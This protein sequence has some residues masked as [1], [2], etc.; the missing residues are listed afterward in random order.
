MKET[1]SLP[2]TDFLMHNKGKVCKPDRYKV[3]DPIQF[4][5]NN[6]LGDDRVFV[7]HDG[8]PYANGSI[9][10]GHA[11]NKILKDFAVKTHYFDGDAVEYHLGW[12][13]H[14]LPIER[15][16][17]QEM[18]SESD[19]EPCHIALRER[20][21]KYAAEQVG[22][23]REQFRRLGIVADWDHPYLTMDFHYEAM[24]F[25]A[26]AKLAKEG[27]VYQKV[28]P[29]HWS[30][31]ERTAIAESEVVYK[32]R[33]D[34]AIYVVFG[35]D[36]NPEPP[37][38]LTWTTTPWT[39]PANVALAVA[40]GEKYVEVETRHHHVWIAEKCLDRLAKEEV[41]KGDHIF[42]TCKAE[43]LVNQEFCT[44]L[45][46]G[47]LHSKV[48]LADFVTMDQGTGIVHIAP[49][50]GMDDYKVGQANDLPTLMPVGE[51]GCYTDEV[52]RLVPAAMNPKEDKDTLVGR[53]V[54]EANNIIINMLR[55]LHLLAGGDEYTH[56]YP[57]CER[58]GKPIIFRATPNWF[59][60]LTKVKDRA[61]A[62]LDEIDF[63]PDSAREKLRLMIE[64]R[65]EWCISRQ[66]AWGVPIAFFE[67][68]QTKEVLLDDDVLEHTASIFEKYGCDC[69]WTAPDDF[70]LP[71]R[72]HGDVRQPDAP[73]YRYERCFD[74]L[75]VWFD[76]G[77]SWFEN[78]P[79]DQNGKQSAQ[80]YMEG[81]DQF[82]GWF[83][84]SLLLSLLIQDAVPF[85][86][87]IAH[88]FVVD[89]QGH[90]MSK[91]AGNVVDPMGV[92][93]EY[94]PDVLRLWVAMTNYTD[95]V[96]LSGEQLDRAK[97]AYNKI[98]NTIRYCL[99]NLPEDKNPH[100][101]IMDLDY[102]IIN[103][104]NFV[105]D[106]VWNDFLRYEYHVGMRKLMDFITGDISGLYMNAVKDRLYCDKG[107]R[108]HSAHTALKTILVNLVNVL[109]PILTYTVEE[110]LD[111]A[112]H[113]LKKSHPHV[114]TLRPKFEW[115]SQTAGKFVEGYWKEALKEFNACF[116]SLKS[117]GLV[118][119]S[120]EVVVVR[121][122]GEVM[123][124]ALA[125]AEKELGPGS[126]PQFTGA[127]DFLGVSD[128]KDQV[129]SLT[130]LGKQ[131]ENYLGSFRVSW[132]EGRTDT[133]IVF[134][135][136][137]HKCPRC[138]KRNAL[139]E[140]EVCSRCKEVIK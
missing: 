34:K 99:A 122:L 41:V 126:V 58:S 43:D 61:L 87:L 72:L 68:R 50:H 59:V 101:Q 37:G 93:D 24:L 92:I 46:A 51:D 49:G 111:H 119:D 130:E 105:C 38:M 73:K 71:P 120:L 18:E 32:T 42:N 117:E 121:N 138:W 70:F 45:G 77:M 31:A 35:S 82:R 76:S 48:V 81:S 102:W 54:F 3:D 94:G 137:N 60:D 21:R 136:E 114:F 80:C 135:S 33:P 131:S 128:L 89:N 74:T 56:E 134:R 86:D 36:R 140:G 8:P 5:R 124:P 47:Q 113:W 44:P 28:R 55:D 2:K 27:T 110:V 65:D 115:K 118:K 83:Q 14:G 127:A 62:A 29:V 15:R 96:K 9:H 88:G 85:K 66:R 23:Q 20:C 7:L 64:G 53:N 78:C 139:I 100:V 4:M 112:P 13:C 95:D 40:P 1:L 22:H 84:S 108:Q 30:W 106:V 52:C 19:L 104:C 132:A 91:S 11:M 26:M 16:I 133:F 103:K 69:W 17:Y 98:R 6:R 10:I 107:A 123:E 116:D 125:A 39:L 57:Y 97:D 25:R 12:D 109:S 129:T 90:K 79:P 75:D 67:D 63:L